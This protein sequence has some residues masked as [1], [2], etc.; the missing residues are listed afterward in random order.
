MPG[1]VPP[2]S[3]EAEMSVLGAMMIFPSALEKCL[4]K[5]KAEM[6]Y[7]PVHK[8][9]FAALANLVH[10]DE[11]ADMLT[12]VD[13]LKRTN[14]LDNIAS[15]EQEARRYIVALTESVLAAE[16]IEH[17]IKL[18][19]N[20]WIARTFI[21]QKSQEI[22]A[23]YAGE[24]EIDQIMS[25]SLS[26]TDLLMRDAGGCE[27]RKLSDA[28][29][30]IWDDLKSP[31]VPGIPF[32]FD[33]LRR[34]CITMRPGEFIVVGANTGIGKSVLAMQ[35]LTHASKCGHEGG[36]LAL[37]MSDK[38]MAYRELAKL[39]KV[40]LHTM[41]S[42]TLADHHWERIANAIADGSE[43]DIY[44]VD[45]ID[46]NTDQMI[47]AVRRMAAKGVKIVAIDH[48]GLVSSNYRNAD[49]VS[50][51]TEVAH[52]C[53]AL[54]RKLD[55]VVIGLCQFNR[56]IEKRGFN[57]KPIKADLKDSGSIEAIADV[58]LFPWREMKE[59]KDDEAE[60]P[61]PIQSYAEINVIKNRMLGPGVAK[62]GWRGRE[63]R[64]VDLEDR[65]SE[66]SN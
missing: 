38:Q 28:Y 19:Y 49:K 24:E 44:T 39:S 17:H 13:E 23:I 32:E 43:Q 34:I 40:S 15:N 21:E 9:I 50:R 25:R 60:A 61:E 18:V 36:I 6:F 11:P 53:K 3:V 20:H 42:R 2:N 31:T 63:F 59:K 27:I 46:F 37:E 33:A 41:Y 22:A 45:A 14:K 12:L 66:D 58:I 29:G 1:K 65:Y 16:H 62:L 30:D 10:R 26:N 35:L 7:R 5:L 4:V 64:F 54:A 56:D 57:A 51:A 47:T 8:I 55:I 52:A 48:M